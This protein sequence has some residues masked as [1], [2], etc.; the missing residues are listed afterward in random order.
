MPTVI[1]IEYVFITAYQT[2]NIYDSDFAHFRKNQYLTYIVLY[3]KLCVCNKKSYTINNFKT[4]KIKYEEI[5][6]L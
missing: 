2:I 4:E 6:F 1:F 3:Y 5:G